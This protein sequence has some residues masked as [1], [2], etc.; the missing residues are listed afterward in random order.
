MAERRVDSGGTGSR[1]SPAGNR[2]GNPFD[3]LIIIGSR[4]ELIFRRNVH[5][6][7][8]GTRQIT[9][10]PGSKHQP[11]L[12]RPAGMSNFYHRRSRKRLRR[13]VSNA[14]CKLDAYFTRYA[15]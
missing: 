2:P 9:D 15:S 5:H 8:P 6:S 1:Y 7:I 3:A 14:D 13:E 12:P 4:P 10:A 11:A